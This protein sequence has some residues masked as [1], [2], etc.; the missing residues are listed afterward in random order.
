MNFIRKREYFIW[1]YNTSISIVNF[2]FIE[3]INNVVVMKN[4]N[5]KDKEKY[6]AK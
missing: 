2:F 4:K 3:K 1:N 6:E 5:T